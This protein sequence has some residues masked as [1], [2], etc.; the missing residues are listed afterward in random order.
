[1]ISIV[2]EAI[3]R[4][5]E[6]QYP[7][8]DKVLAAMEAYGDAKQFP[9]VGPQVG[10]LLF[11]LTQLVKATRIFEIGSGFGYSA[12]WFAQGLAAGGKVIQTEYSRDHSEKAREFFGKAG[13][14]QR[15]EFLVGD[16]LELIGHAKGPFDIVFLDLDKEKYPEAFE[17]AAERIRPGG[18]L[19]A[20]NTLWFGRVLA[21]AADAETQGILE[22]TRRLFGDRRFFSAIL[23]IRDGIAVGLRT[24]K[25]LAD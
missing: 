22:F 23:P 15:A 9:F 21:P 3:N 11:I 6:G 13:L 5:I 16:G 4:Y 7:K 2:H 10:R 24:E 25:S 12:Y 18:L 20:D 19:I 8:E 14:S 1:M 17:K